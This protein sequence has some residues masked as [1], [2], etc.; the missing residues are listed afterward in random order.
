M[1][2]L[3]KKAKA[4]SAATRAAAQR[5]ILSLSNR[6][7]PVTIRTVAVEA[8]VSESYLTKQADLR[9]QIRSIVGTQQHAPRAQQVSASTL[10]ANQTK[11]LVMADRIRELEAETR[12]LRDENAA[13]R[14]EILELRRAN[15]RHKPS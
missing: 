2:R 13:L 11:L 8:G 4:R 5:A 12:T 10:A 1:E 6:G 3:T 15:R 14:G 9:D 7:L